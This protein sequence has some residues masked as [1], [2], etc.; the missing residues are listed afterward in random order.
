VGAKLWLLKAWVVLAQ[1]MKAWWGDKASAGARPQGA[2]MLGIGL[3]TKASG[4]AS[5]VRSKIGEHT[6]WHPQGL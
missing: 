6:L 2:S 3:A 1:E 4:V 5:P